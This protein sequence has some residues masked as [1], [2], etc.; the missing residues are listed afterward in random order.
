MQ[1][2]EREYLRKKLNQ[3]SRRVETRY[4]Q[5]NMKHID[6]QFGVTTTNEMRQAYRSVL[7]WCT[8]AVDAIAD[9]L[10]FRGF[11][12]DNFEMNE[13]FQLNNPTTLFDS[14]IL[15]ALISSCSFIYIAEPEPGED[16]PRMQVIDGANATG[17]LDPVTGLLSQGYAVLRR[18]EHGKPDIEAFLEPYSTE[19]RYS[20]AGGRS[21]SEF[22]NHGVGYPLLVPIIH[23][24][25]A[26]RPFGRSRISRAAEYYQAYAKRVLE[27]SDITA[28]FYS[29]PQKYA[30]GLSDEAETLDS[31]KASISAMLSFTKDSD[32]DS[33]KLGQF[34]VSSMSPF[35]EQLRTIASVFA[36]ETGL[37]LDDL[38]FQTDNPSSSE[39]IKASHETLRAGAR[40]AQRSFGSGFLNA[41]YLAVCLRDSKPYARSAIYRTRPI[42]E[43]VFEAD[44]STLTMVGDAV[45]KINEAIP[46]YIDGRVIRN[47]TGLEGTERGI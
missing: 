20:R 27:R 25:D 2:I 4:R 32:G 29:F 28:E 13:V 26:T 7:G 42:W 6:R 47:F 43:P 10:V 45:I 19:I 44:A 8:T 1:E 22:Y 23:R 14:A 36:G 46:G 21:H 38:G 39:A 41:G 9:R 18:D 31:W 33:P 12:D 30:T 35:M 37:T 17:K 11:E 15:G 40:R 5:Y 16:T 24:P 34:A 3:H